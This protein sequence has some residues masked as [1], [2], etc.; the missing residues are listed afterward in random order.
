MYWSPCLTKVGTVKSTLNS[1]ISLAKYSKDYDVTIINVFGEWS[2]YEKY[3]N[4]NNVNLK[5]LTFN[6]YNFLPKNGFIKSRFS[7]IIIFLISAF[8]L[9][10]FIKSRKPDY[11]IIH[12]ITSLPLFLLNLFNLQTRVILRISGFPKNDII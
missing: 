5:N 4:Q 12:L 1:A 8:P 11:L 9:L 10:F 2:N 7:Y 3:L 6:Y